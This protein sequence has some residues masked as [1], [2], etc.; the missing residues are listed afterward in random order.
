MDDTTAASVVFREIEDLKDL[1]VDPD[2]LQRL[3][4]RIEVEAGG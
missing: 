2:E 3:E 4:W 1:A